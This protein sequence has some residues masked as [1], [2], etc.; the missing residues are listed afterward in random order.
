MLNICRISEILSGSFGNRDLVYMWE[1][2]KKIQVSKNYYQ[3]CNI[4]SRLIKG[5]GSRRKSRKEKDFN[6]QSRR[7]WGHSVW[8]HV[9]GNHRRSCLQPS[10]WY[11]MWPQ[12][13]DPALY[14]LLIN[15]S[16][17]F[18]PPWKGPKDSSNTIENDY[19]SFGTGHYQQICVQ[20]I[21]VKYFWFFLRISANEESL[22]SRQ[23]YRAPTV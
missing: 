10:P 12:A 14:F 21:D 11:I 17:H 3:N 2:Q 4:R 23:I 18:L 22:F 7:I 6:C 19:F 20:N 8:K 5:S 13:E 15:W 16:W 9:S 1:K